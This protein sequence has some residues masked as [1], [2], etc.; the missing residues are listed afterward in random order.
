MVDMQKSPPPYST[1][2]DGSSSP[3]PRQHPIPA[4]IKSSNFIQ[5]S[6]PKTVQGVWVIDPELTPPASLMSP[7]SGHEERKNVLIESQDDNVNIDL[8]VLP[9]PVL[10]QKKIS[11]KLNS[12]SGSASVRVVRRGV[13][14][15]PC[16]GAYLR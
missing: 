7:P 13:C 6:T 2:Q 15:L 1:T 14:W 12:W 9:S 16:T 10:Q 4:D 8:F 11:M 3:A 5:I